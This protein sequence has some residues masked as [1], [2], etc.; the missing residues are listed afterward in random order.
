MNSIINGLRSL[1]NKTKEKSQE[2]PLVLKVRCVHCGEPI[3]IGH[4]GEWYHDD[5]EDDPNDELYGNGLCDNT[6]H[7]WF[8]TPPHPLLPDH[9]AT[10]VFKKK[11][12][13]QWQ[14]M[15]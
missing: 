3:S 14:D 11:E 15:Q 4:D 10:Y 2:F 8:A 1:L 12:K 5:L 9:S 7:T 6:I 13:K